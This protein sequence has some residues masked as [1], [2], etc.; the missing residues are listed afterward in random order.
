M[1]AATRALSNANDSR[2]GNR[3]RAAA[4]S[5]ERY[6]GAAARVVLCCP[7]PCATL[8]ASGPRFNPPPSNLNRCAPPMLFFFAWIHL[9]SGCRNGP[10]MKNFLPWPALTSAER[11]C[12]AMLPISLRVCVT[13]TVSSEMFGTMKSL[14]RCFNP[15]APALSTDRVTTMESSSLVYPEKSTPTSSKT[16]RAAHSRSG[17]FLLIF[18]LGKPQ[19]LPLFQPLTISTLS[20]CGFKMTRPAVGML[21]L[22]MRKFL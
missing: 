21:S 11:L 10:T 7:A 18:P 4:S 17:S 14:E 19:E 2:L 6:T 5:S 16:S 15:G 1:A 8:P 22:Y 20:I 3:A 13:N 9:S 12:H